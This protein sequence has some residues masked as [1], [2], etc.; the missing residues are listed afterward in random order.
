VYGLLAAIIDNIEYTNLTNLIWIQEVETPRYDP[1][2]TNATA[3]HT[4]K[5]MDDKLEEKRK[6]WYIHKGFLH[7][8][9]MN[10]CNVLDKQY[11][12][13]LKNVNTAYHNTTLIQILKHLNTPWCPLNV[14]ACKMIKK[15]FV[16]IG[17]V[18]SPFQH[19][20]L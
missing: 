10:M 20:C 6:L 13:Q 15:E 12:S 11:Y 9:T 1:S 7:G 17:L 5:C 3:I 19:T 2:I 4:R 14:Q 16:D 18:E 8:V